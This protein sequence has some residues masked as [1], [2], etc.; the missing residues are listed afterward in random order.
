MFRIIVTLIILSGL[1]Q[2]ASRVADVPPGEAVWILAQV[3]A[4]RQ[5]KG[6]GA[7]VVNVQLSTSAAGHS[8]Y[9]ATHAWSD[10]HTESNGSTPSS[11]A[12]LRTE[13]LAWAF[14]NPISSIDT[15]PRGAGAGAG[16]GGATVTGVAAGAAFG[17]ASDF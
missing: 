9:L 3:N 15:G 4:L 16:A 17:A 10:P 5:A 6:E 14:E 1:S 11:R 2:P 7:L 8:T 13:G 12:N